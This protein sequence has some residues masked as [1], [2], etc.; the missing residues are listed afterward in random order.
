MIYKVF[1]VLFFLMLTAV[2]CSSQDIKVLDNNS[3]EH[4]GISY[5]RISLQSVLEKDDMAIIAY[6]EYL[7][8]YH[9]SKKE[10]VVGVTSLLS[11]VAV[12]AIGFQLFQKNKTDETLMLVGA[13]AF[14]TGAGLLIVSAMPVGYMLDHAIDIYNDNPPDIGM[15]Q[16]HLEAGLTS[17]GVGLVYQF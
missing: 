13:V 8:A 7:R 12:A 10:A 14:I 11:G 16:P 15:R 2:I 6:E 17:N 5:D 3:F 4:Q 9:R 1:G